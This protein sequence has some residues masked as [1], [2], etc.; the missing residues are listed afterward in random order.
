MGQPEKLLHDPE[1]KE[2]S[3]A[4]SRRRSPG[5]KPGQFAII[6]LGITLGHGDL[7]DHD[8][9]PHNPALAAAIAKKGGRLSGRPTFNRM[10][11]AA[12]IGQDRCHNLDHDAAA[13]KRLLDD[14]FPDARDQPT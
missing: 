4:S 8:L 6:L 13:I 12:K 1:H 3:D 14:L 10:V 7:I 11:H 9:L 5:R 2:C